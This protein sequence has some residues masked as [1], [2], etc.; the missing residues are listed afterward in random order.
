MQ[1]DVKS[2]LTRYLVIPQVNQPPVRYSCGYIKLLDH[3]DL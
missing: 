1:A 3:S 2:C